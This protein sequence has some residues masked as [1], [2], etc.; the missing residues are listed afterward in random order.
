MAEV[1]Q[2]NVGNTSSAAALAH[3]LYEMKVCKPLK[4]L[5]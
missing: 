5:D 2:E 1:L 3:W 4:H